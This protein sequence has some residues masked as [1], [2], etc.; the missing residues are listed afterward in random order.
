MTRVDAPWLRDAAAQS[1][2]DALAAAGGPGCVR[3]VGGCVRDALLDRAGGDVDLATTLRPEQTIAAL[4]SAGLKA[5]PTGVEHGTVTAVSD[6]RPFEITTLRRDVET[7]GRRA[8]VAFT[9]DWSE[10]AHRRDFRLNALYADAEGRVFDPVGE[11][12]ADARAGRIVFVGEP[13]RRIEEDHL[14]ILRFFRFFAWFGRGAPDPEGLEAC[15]EMADGVDHLSAERIS[16][17]LLKLLAA[18]APGTAV[19]AMEAAGVLAR[20]LGSPADLDRFEAVLARDSDPLLRL[21]AL[22]PDDSAFVASAARRL[23]LPKVAWTRLAAA[24]EPLDLDEPT[25]QAVRRLVHAVGTR[26]AMDRALKSSD[27]AAAGVVQRVAARWTPP[28]LP[29]GG[30]E[31]ARL[32]VPA[33]PETGAVLR[34]FEASWV[35]DDFPMDDVDRRLAAALSA[36]RGSG[37]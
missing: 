22:W 25:E 1:V 34:A 12:V 36:V 18:P 16:A 9:D 4:K 17:E 2:I 7:D 24:A 23:R 30:R 21:S 15:R 37:R 32:G 11:G 3:F 27:A 19:R 33:G 14:R 6:R 10:D 31:V 35:A 20:V 5:V 26:A 29:V 8:V 28:A 13:R